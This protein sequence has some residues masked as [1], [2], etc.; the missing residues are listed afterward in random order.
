MVSITTTRQFDAIDWL[1]AAL[2]ARP[3]LASGVQILDA[4]FDLDRATE[5]DLLVLHGTEQTEDFG[6]IGNRRQEEEFDLTGEI[7]V[8]RAGGVLHDDL[9]TCRDRAKAILAEL[10]ETVRLDPHM[11]G[12]VS[13]SR[14][15]RLAVHQ[16]W[17][18]K[19]RLV[20]VPFTVR[21]HATLP[22]A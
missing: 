12:L 9:K 8:F 21:A 16:G 6:A 18:D 13:W 17:N 19:G 15:S 11:G 7:L 3:A 10:E 14:I 2:V 1:Y 5:P 20:L 22:K 4:A